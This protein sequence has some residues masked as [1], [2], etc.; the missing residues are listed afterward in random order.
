MPKRDSV[1]D[2]RDTL[3]RIEAVICVPNMQYGLEE[4]VADIIADD[5]DGVIAVVDAPAAGAGA[6]A[7][8]G[9]DEFALAEGVGV[10]EGCGG[11]GGGVDADGGHE[12]GGLWV[13]G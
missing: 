13:R 10:G 5:D 7:L 9:E 12:D 3:A 8:A 11:V 2:G 4:E 6:E 1:V